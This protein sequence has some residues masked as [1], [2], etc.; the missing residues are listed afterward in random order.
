MRRAM[1]AV[2]PSSNVP[3]GKALT[4][5]MVP[6]FANELFQKDKETARDE[7]CV[8]DN[9]RPVRA[10][11][12]AVVPAEFAGCFHGAADKVLLGDNIKSTF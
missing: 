2:M 11:P 9:K 7:R 4:K 1:P 3:L 6:C 8:G 5:M 12:F 10:F